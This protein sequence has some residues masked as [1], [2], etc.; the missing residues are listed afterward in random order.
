MD[1]TEVDYDVIVLGGG[2]AGMAA[3][4]EAAEAGARVLLVDADRK[5]GGSTALSGGVFYAAGTSVQH[6]A[7]ISDTPA[8]QFRYYMNVNQ[9]KLEPSLVHRLCEDSAPTLEWLMS[10]GVEFRIEDLYVAGVDGV[11]RGHRAAGHGAA[12]AAALEASLVGKRVD[13]ALNTRILKLLQESGRVTGV[14]TDENV[15]RAGAVVV[16]TGGFGNDSE[17][18]AQFYPDATRHPDIAWY[19]GSKHARG[20]GIDL[21]RQVGAELAGHNR[22]LLLLT[23][24]FNRE[25]EPYLPG[26]LMFVNR[27]GRRFVN[28][29]TEY[30]V[31]AEVLKEQPAGECFAIFDENSRVSS[32]SPAAPNW[33]AERLAEFAANGKLTVRDSLPEL[34]EAL[35]VDAE[36]LGTTV[37][38]YNADTEVGNDSRF[39]K[40]TE[41]LRSISQ[42]PFYAAPIK[43]AVICWTGTGLRIDREARVLGSA[44]RSIHG[45]FAAGEAT[46]GMFGQCY[47]AGGASIANA[48]IFGRIAGRNAALVSRPT[49]PAVA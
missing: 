10:L 40:G 37:A 48:I 23:S 15:V 21:G 5:L 47:A 6:A 44:D 14:V 18:L 36:T 3:A 33:S 22:G 34:A 32:R 4:I 11:A 1:A 24:G 17:K 41:W 45:L 46:G 42:P 31:L 35:G 12:I 43:P 13:V 20:D 29:R 19:I 25:L 8:E 26:W 16:A 49:A 9:H 7:G 38:H 28:E 27:H 39:F 30:S 2:G